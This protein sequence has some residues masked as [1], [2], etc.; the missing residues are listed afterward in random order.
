MPYQFKLEALRRY[1][2]FEE[3]RLQKELADAQRVVE[4][5][6][7]LLKANMALRQK[8][9]IEFRKRSQSGETP[10][11]QAAMYRGYLQ[12]LAAE[13]IV[14]HQ[15]VQSAEKA[16]QRVRDALLDA[17]KRRKAL[18]RL[19]EKGEQTFM[20]ELNSQEQ[21]FINEMAIQRFV[22]KEE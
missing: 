16:C 14:H 20:A 10:A 15:Q 9:E 18:D 22:R 2:Q 21:K 5:A 12:R 19:K 4:Q 7:A 17:M 11:A 8:T 13:I 1:R 3:D 6:Q